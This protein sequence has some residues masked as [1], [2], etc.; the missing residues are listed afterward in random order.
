MLRQPFL[1]FQP[2]ALEKR[3]E[4][5]I[6]FQIF[7]SLHY[8][9]FQPSGVAGDHFLPFD[10]VDPQPVD[11]HQSQRGFEQVCT[12]DQN[13]LRPTWS[14]SLEGAIEYIALGIG[15]HKVALLNT[16]RERFREPFTY[17]ATWSTLLR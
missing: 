6:D 12:A 15:E 9:S 14:I 13:R 11:I 10:L 3:T 16:G 5:Y 17:S 7:R 4:C 8:H 1:R 2:N